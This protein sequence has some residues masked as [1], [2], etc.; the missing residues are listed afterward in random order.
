MARSVTR[1]GKILP[2]W[3]NFKN[4]WPFI[5]GLN[6]ILNI[7]WQLIYAIKQILFV[8]NDQ[9]LIK[10]YGHTGGGQRMNEKEMTGNIFRVG[11]IENK[12]TRMRACNFSCPLFSNGRDGSS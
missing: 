12:F 7:F 10:P 11:S 3:Q 8:V 1:F 4:L 5:E 2:L 6:I 9:I